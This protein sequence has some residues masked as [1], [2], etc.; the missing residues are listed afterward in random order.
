ME[1][2]NNPN[3]PLNPEQPVSGETKVPAPEVAPQAPA[4]TPAPSAP[5]VPASPPSAPAAPQPAP[6]S[7]P[8][9]QQSTPEIVPGVGANPALAGDVDVIEKEWV[10]QAEKV[11]EQTKDDPYIQEEAVE[12]LQQDYLKKRYGRDV[13]KPDQEG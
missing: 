4:S 3:V 6:V 9:T 12:S 1:P 8:G 13:A 7:N 5:A 10:D 11:V 2:T